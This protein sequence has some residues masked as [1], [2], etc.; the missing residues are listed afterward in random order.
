M[1]KKI[2]IDT[3]VLVSAILSAV[4]NPGKIFYEFIFTKRSFLCISAEIFQEYVEVCNR[5]KFKRFPFFEYRAN[6]FLIYILNF[7]NNY[8]PNQHFDLLKDK[9]DNKFIDLAFEANAHYIITGNTKDFKIS[10]HKKTLIVTPKEF[11]KLQ[12]N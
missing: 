4:S 1:Q 7:S 2:V 10:K 6:L 11:L 3:N 5:D 8:E 9:S 12:L